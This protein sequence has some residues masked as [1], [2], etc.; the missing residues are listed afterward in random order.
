MNPQTILIVED[1]RQIVRFLELELQHEGYAVEVAYNGNDGLAAVERDKPDLVLL[2]VMLPG[3]HGLEVC[4]RVRQFSDV[5][6][7]ML[8]ARD[9]TIDKVLGLDLGANDYITKPFAIEE[10]LARIRAALR[11]KSAA[12]NAK[13]LSIYDLSMDL[14][15]HIVTRGSARIELTK[16]EFDLLEYLILNCGIVLTREQILDNVWGYAFMGDTKIVDVYIRYLRN[17]MDDK[18]E[19]KLI[20]TVRGVGYILKEESDEE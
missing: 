11:K 16:R 10:L 9:E 6:I 19:V 1:E 3:L 18:S 12:K 8:T 2:D 20:N 4:R 14:S 17:K 15:S 5:P 7:I 13:V